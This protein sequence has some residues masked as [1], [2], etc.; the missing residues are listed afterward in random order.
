ML[1]YDSA[2]FQR[3]TVTINT[4]DGYFLISFLCDIVNRHSLHSIPYTTVNRIVYISFYKRYTSFYR[5]YWCYVKINFDLT[6]KHCVTS[7]CHIGT[8]QTTFHEVMDF[9]MS[10]SSADNL[11]KIEMRVITYLTWTILDVN[12]CLFQG[13]SKCTLTHIQLDFGSLFSFAVHLII[14]FALLVRLRI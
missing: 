3:N 10:I 5:S 13:K 7:S 1:N 8:F 14:S 4:N 11:V 6:N 12:S 9:Q 2:H